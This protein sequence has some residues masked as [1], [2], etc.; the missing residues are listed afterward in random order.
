MDAGGYLRLFRFRSFGE[1]IWPVWLNT[2]NK[3]AAITS[4][5]LK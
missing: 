5:C 4:N 1:R 2:A 3:L